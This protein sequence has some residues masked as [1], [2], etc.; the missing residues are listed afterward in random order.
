[1][2]VCMYVC[3]CMYVRMYVCIYI[4]VCMYVRMC[5]FTYLI[6]F[7]CLRVRQRGAIRLPLDGFLW[8]LI[9]E[10]FSKI[11]RENPSLIKT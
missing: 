4:Y 9:F 2:Y 3:V 1:M 11:C 7:V 10:D 5:V 6:M 8:D